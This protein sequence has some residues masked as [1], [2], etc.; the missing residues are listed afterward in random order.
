[1]NFKLYIVMYHYVRELRYSR[2][3][4]IKGLDYQLF[5]EQ[6]Q[7]L[8]KNFSIV[9]MEDVIEAYNFG[10]ALPDKACLLTFDDGYVDD[11]LSVFPALK[12]EKVQ[13]SF[14]IPGKTFAE[15]ELLDVNK[16]HF[17]IANAKIDFL[18]RDLFLEIN[19]YRC[20]MPEIP[21]NERL[22]QIYARGNRF[23]NKET[24]FVKRILQTVLP[25]NIRRK[26]AANL[27]EKYVGIPENVFARELYLSTDQIRCMKKG[28]MHIGIH[29]YDHYWLGNLNK[30]KMIKDLDMALEVM[31]EFIDL[32]NWTMNYPYGSYSDDVIEYI[33]GKGCKLAMTTAVGVASNMDN[34]FLLPRL[35]CNDFPPKS[36]KYKRY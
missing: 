32:N 36:N 15:N 13:G 16:V 1:M 8:K 30:E 18:V 17:I 24:I 12:E 4:A 35:D 29:G 14:F 6:I 31:N 3:P 33:S 19:R 7:Y 22:F 25:E 28:G 27:F 9:T 10:G 11:F 34:R 26:I 2:Y 20:E 21:S 5:K 23:D